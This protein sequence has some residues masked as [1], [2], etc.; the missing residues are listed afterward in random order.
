MHSVNKIMPN[1]LAMT[2]KVSSEGSIVSKF[3]HDLL[4]IH[5]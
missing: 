4:T 2:G 3:L 1:H 5:Y